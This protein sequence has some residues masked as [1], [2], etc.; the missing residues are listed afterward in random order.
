[1]NGPGA[2]VF[3]RLRDA[4]V[5]ARDAVYGQ[6]LEAFGRAMVANTEAQRALHPQLVGTDAQQVIDL[7]NRHGAAGWKVNGAGGDGGSIT[8]LS[9]TRADKDAL[10]RR[11]AASDLR[12]R[13]L[14]IEISD[15]GVEVR[16][17]L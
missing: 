12:Y 10:E 1:M 11:I 7:A 16:G 9:T 6:D 2:E 3:T 15:A 8:I 17:A 13:V 14:P 4:A 5:A